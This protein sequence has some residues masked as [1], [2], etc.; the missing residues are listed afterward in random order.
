MRWTQTSNSCRPVQSGRVQRMNKCAALK[1]QERRG[2]VAST[3]ACTVA[4]TC[5]GAYASA[6]I[7]TG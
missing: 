6:G 7:D 4:R 3:G 1:G 2:E 5:T